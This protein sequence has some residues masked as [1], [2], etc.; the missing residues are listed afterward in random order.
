VIS[1]WVH[2]F[3]RVRNTAVSSDFDDRPSSHINTRPGL[4]ENCNVKI[5][6]TR[7]C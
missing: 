5:H 2:W 1:C 4:W 7:V 6:G 3:A